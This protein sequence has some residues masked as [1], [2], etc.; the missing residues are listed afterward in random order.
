[1]IPQLFHPDEL[2]AQTL[3]GFDRVGGGIY[4]RCRISTARF[5]PRCPTCLSPRWTTGLAHRHPVQ[6][7]A[8]IFTHAG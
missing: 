2:R 8:R 3:A 7:P 4:P 1:M 6:R 5:S